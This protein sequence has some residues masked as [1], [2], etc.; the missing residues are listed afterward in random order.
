M[1]APIEDHHDAGL[2]PVIL[3]AW[4]LALLILLALVWLAIR[5]LDR[6]LGRSSL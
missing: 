1:S 3:G 2:M 6:V 5:G 4:A